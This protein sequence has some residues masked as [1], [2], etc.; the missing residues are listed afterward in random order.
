MRPLKAQDFAHELTPY[1][2]SLDPAKIAAILRELADAVEQQAVQVQKIEVRE[3]A[4][5]E[6][7]P[8]TTLEFGFSREEQS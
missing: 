2:W 1:G 6:D 7:F 3:L 5:R 8:M 4:S